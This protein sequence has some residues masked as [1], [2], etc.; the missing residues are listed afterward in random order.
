MEEKEYTIDLMEIVEILKE[1]CKPIAKMTGFM[2]GATVIFVVLAW[3]FFPS[4]ESETMLQI[5][6]TP[7]SRT[8]LLTGMGAPSEM[9]NYKQ[10]L[11]SRGVVVPVIKNSEKPNSSGKYPR[12]EEYIKK[13]ITTETVKLSEILFVKVK[14]ESAEK[15][16]KTNQL[17][18]ESFLKR[19]GEINS[20]QKGNLKSFLIERVAT[21]KE[22]LVKAEM[23]LQK[24]KE[25]NK[26]L[27]PSANAEIFAERIMEA[28]KKAAANRIELEAAQARL[29]SINEQLHSSGA[30]SADNVTIQKYN[31]E[32]AKLETARI[33]Y[34]DK[35]TEKH[36]RMIE[37]NERIASLK[38][39]IQIETGKIA[40]LQAPSDNMVHQGLVA[41]KYSAEGAISVAKQKA[42]ALQKLIEK[43]NADLAKMPE[44]EQNYI[45]LARDYAV[46]NEIY[47]M[48]VKQLEETKITE[49]QQ[50]MNVWLVDPP[51]LP[52][53]PSFPRPV[54]MPVIGALIGLLL[55][56]AF[57]TYKEFQ[58]RTIR[59][60][61]MV[62]QYAEL[63]V[64]G[65]IPSKACPQGEMQNCIFNNRFFS[66]LKEYIWKK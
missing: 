47:M 4:Y 15:A 2:L 44:M 11:L 13:K 16:Q 62:A 60:C 20:T 45:R 18:I 53:R 59:S 56:C 29:A 34:Q 39:K 28:E 35:Y 6:S 23:A 51:H 52:D 42:E 38:A 50:P 54:F 48:L 49:F 10:I 63:T 61:N 40:N 22:E 37:I 9:E 43:N 19:I 57:V 7:I 3:F 21:A 1:N 26:I 31:E 8:A 55:S 41:G 30:A 46:A 64:F 65:V 36:P 58:N 27:S 32:L 5:K 33:T 17:L 66:K 12:Y 14:G 25:D 24:F